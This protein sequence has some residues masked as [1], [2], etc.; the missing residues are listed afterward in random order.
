MYS[1]SSLFLAA[2]FSIGQ[3]SSIALSDV[4]IANRPTVRLVGNWSGRQQRIL[5]IRRNRNIELMERQGKPLATGLD[6][7]LFARPAP[8]ERSLQ[9]LAIQLAELFPLAK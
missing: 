5:L 6:V 4:Y 2:Q 7:G 9:L 3:G 8:Q 1:T